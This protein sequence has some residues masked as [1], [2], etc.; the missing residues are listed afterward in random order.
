MHFKSSIL[1]QHT[2]IVV[3]LLVILLFAIY[4]SQ[5][6]SIGINKAKTNCLRSKVF[7][8]DKWDKTVESGQLLAFEMNKD[9]QYYPKGSIWVK[10]VAG[11]SGDIVNVDHYSVMVAGKT[12]NL[13]TTYIYSKLDSSPDEL[14]P[15]WHL[16][17]DDV[18][19]IGETLFSY[20]SRFWGPIKRSDV[21]GRAYA[22]F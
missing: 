1:K 18:F 21:K 22:I 2:S 12:Y 13:P 8:I 19:M 6:Y 10:K 15:V 20:D 9:T 17:E 3:L 14:T 5:R 16:A 7:L 4:F 11:S